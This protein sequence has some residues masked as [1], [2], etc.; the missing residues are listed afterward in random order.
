[1]DPYVHFHI[2]DSKKVF[3]IAFIDVEVRK[4]TAVCLGAL[5]RTI[6]KLTFVLC[7]FLWLL[8]APSDQKWQV[9]LHALCLLAEEIRL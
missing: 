1:M 2:T 3:L 6:I 4:L 5:T 7:A 9:L 8:A